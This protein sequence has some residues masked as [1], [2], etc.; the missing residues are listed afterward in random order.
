[1]EFVRN[2]HF[3]GNQ[4]V[5]ETRLIMVICHKWSFE[6]EIKKILIKGR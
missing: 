5:M 3:Y 6:I 4:I 2:M 1:M